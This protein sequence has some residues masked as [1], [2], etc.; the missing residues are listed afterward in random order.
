MLTLAVAFFGTALLYA[1]VGFAGGSTYNALLVL[2][3]VDHRIF[4]VIA[5]VCNLIVATGAAS[6][7]HGPDWCRGGG[8]GRCWLSLSLRRGSGAPCPFQRRCSY[9]CWEGRCSWQA[10]Y[11]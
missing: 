10:L 5:L 2:A 8:C 9:C 7:L 6:A 4:P 11:C 1:S 3:G